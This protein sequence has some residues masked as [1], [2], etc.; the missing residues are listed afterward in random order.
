[1]NRV[2]AQRAM[3][4]IETAVWVGGQT[5]YYHSN[6]FST[7]FESEDG[8]FVP[9]TLVRFPQGAPNHLS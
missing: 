5:E 6:Q 1:M 3:A 2:L 7:M 8:S 4:S 9:P